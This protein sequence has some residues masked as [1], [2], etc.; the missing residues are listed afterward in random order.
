MRFFRQSRLVSSLRIEERS[1]NISRGETLSGAERRSRVIK[2][3]RLFKKIFIPIISTLLVLGIIFILSFVYAPRYV[4]IE[5]GILFFLASIV[6][7]F[8]GGLQMQLAKRMGK[9][10]S[11]WKQ[12]SIIMGLYYGCF[13]VFTCFAWFNIY[14]R[15]AHDELNNPT[16]MT[17]LA[18]AILLTFGLVIYGTILSFS[19]MKATRKTLA[20]IQARH[21]QAQYEKQT[22]S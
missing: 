2:Q 12:V 10:V 19:Y 17:I 15:F 14:H 11:W 16:G 6:S 13:G 7:F 5:A 22:S 9:P 21:V 18:L 8:V 3:S 4:L 20:E 1:T